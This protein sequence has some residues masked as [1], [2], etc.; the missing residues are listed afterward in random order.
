M[1]RYALIIF[2][3]FSGI[4]L[5]GQQLPLNSQYMLNYFIVNPAVAGSYD[6]TPVNLGVRKQWVNLEGSPASQALNAHTYI[7]NNVGL[8][9]AFYNEVQG[10]SR[11]TGFSVSFAYHLGLSNDFSRKLSFGLS[12]TFYQHQVNT[13]ELTTDQPGDPVIENGFETKLSPDFNFGVMLSEEQTYFV[14]LSIYN[15][16]E[17]RTDLF[18]EMDNKNNPI[19]R[20]FY[21]SGGYTFE[22]NETFDLQPSSHIQ[23]QVNTPVQA[24]LALRGIYDDLVGLGVS[25]RYEDAITYLLSVDISSIR[26]GYSYD[27]TLSTLKNYGTGSHEVHL[28]YRIFKGNSSNSSTPGARDGGLFF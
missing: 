25:Y 13:E 22:I 19:K 5:K 1:K 16:M 28:T 9:A 15:L 3:L 24:E 11:R 23:Y 7:G 17:L 2:V 4:Q 10:P 20:T 8:G 26:I 18:Q 6:H 21:L 12:P 27:M 14:G